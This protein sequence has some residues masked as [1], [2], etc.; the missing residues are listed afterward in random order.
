MTD[1][2]ERPMER[3]SLLERPSFLRSVLGTFGTNVA[4]AALSFVSVVITARALGPSGR[5]EVAFL[6]TVAYL[7]SQLA[8]LG[9]QQANA[10]LAGRRPELSPGLAATSLAIGLAAGAA[11]G[12]LLAGLLVAFPDVGG[13]AAPWLLAL[14]LASAP[15]LIVQV[16]LQYLVVAQYGFRI[17]N[18]AWLLT[19]VI[20][21]VV[22]GT[23]ALTGVLTAG[24]AVS[25]WVLGQFL[26]TL[27]LAW[28]VARRLGGFGRPDGG[29]AREMLSFGIKAHF[30]R[31]ML[32]GNYRLDQWIL[33]VIAGSRELGLYSVA[34]AWAEALFF[35]PTAI[36]TVQ[37]PD[38]VRDSA[39]E[40]ERR[41][42]LLFRA[43]VVLTFV[44]AVAMIVLA[45]FLCVS[46]FGE[47]FRG[48]VTML[49]VLALGALGISAL[50]L[51]GN[52]LTA[53]RRPL[54][55]TA[56]I[57]IAFVATVALD[58]LL[59]PA[60]G[61]VGAAVASTAAYTAGGVVMAAI[62]LRSLKGS[63]RDLVPSGAELRVLWRRVAAARGAAL[64]D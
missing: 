7:T 27:V 64:K 35:L 32:V 37:R 12:V 8:S 15:M 60:H 16:Y 61:G 5:G 47:E 1:A 43:T 59:I 4:V 54:L 52:A 31:V 55:E 49:R 19:P 18:R 57:A 30:G 20:N 6:T 51:L 42:A 17:A 48:S 41:A 36:N 9:V 44:T 39:A 58:L 2:N 53:Q 40:A 22:N 10:N 50:K 25:S 11:A 63:P 14:A 21:V 29:L 28:A 26:T 24:L 33:G 13:G 23:L 45:P 62:F 34:V 3:S 38:L 56:G 46:V